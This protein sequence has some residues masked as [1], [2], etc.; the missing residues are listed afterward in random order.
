MPMFKVWNAARTVKRATVASNIAEIKEKGAQKVLLPPCIHSVDITVVL[1]EDGTVIDE[2]EILLEL[3]GKTL[4]LL[5]PQESWQPVVENASDSIQAPLSPSSALVTGATSEQTVYSPVGMPKTQPVCI[6]SEASGS[7]DSLTDYSNLLQ[8]LMK[9]PLPKFS[10]LVEKHLTDTCIPSVIWQKMI[11]ECGVY[12]MEN[13]PGI[14][15]QSGYKVI[16]EKMY[17]RYPSISLEGERP[18]SVFTKNLS[19]H[20]RHQRHQMKTKS[21]TGPQQESASNDPPAKRL[22]FQSLQMSDSS[23]EVSEEDIGR[24]VEEM[25]AEWKK[26]S[27]KRSVEH[28]KALLRSTRQDRVQ[29]LVDTP[30]GSIS[31]ILERYPCLTDSSYVLYELSLMLGSERVKTMAKNL[32]TLLFVIEDISN[33]IPKSQNDPLRMLAVILY[34]EK[35]IKMKHGGKASSSALSKAASIITLVE[36]VADEDINTALKSRECE[37]PHI[38]VFTAA[39]ELS[40]LYIIGDTVHITVEKNEGIMSAVLKL[41][42]SYYI[43]DLSYPKSHA[44]ILGLLQSFVMEEAFKQKTSQGYKVLFKE[45]REKWNVLIADAPQ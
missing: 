45:V 41:M 5:G 7:T 35:R 17:K 18:W 25:K 26:Q 38:M 31:K 32:K 8:S 10:P 36:D 4:L 44:M 1:E 27:S 40:G 11:K 3:S 42:A 24:H 34:M 19:Q 37:A 33:V 16:G 21:K 14:R 23:Q 43:F 39:G 13:F 12:Y 6:L 20:I 30:S 9:A 28:I 2:D 22:R 29:I 15:D